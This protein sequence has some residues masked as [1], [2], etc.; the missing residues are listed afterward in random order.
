MPILLWL[1]EIQKSLMELLLFAQRQYKSI[2]PTF[3]YQELHH[4]TSIS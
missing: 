2:F 4:M 3:N 1:K